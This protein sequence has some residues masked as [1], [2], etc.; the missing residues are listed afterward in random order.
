MPAHLKPSD[1]AVAARL[2]TNNLYEWQNQ[3]MDAVAAGYQTAL[4]AP[5]GSGKSS[6]VVTFLILWFLHEYPRGRVVVTSGSWTQLENQIFNSLKNFA[7]H[8][9]FQGWKFLDSHVETPAGGF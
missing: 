9:F 3:T 6:T 1:F 8:P 7:G 5:N 2:S 4:C